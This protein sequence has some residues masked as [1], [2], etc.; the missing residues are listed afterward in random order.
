MASLD[1]EHIIWPP[2]ESIAVDISDSVRE[3]VVCRSA[4]EYLS[5]TRQILLDL[6]SHSVDKMAYPHR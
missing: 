4:Y 6:E 1:A 5:H 2:N 3:V